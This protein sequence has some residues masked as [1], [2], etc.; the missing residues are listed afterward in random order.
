[1][2]Y[3]FPK[4]FMPSRSTNICSDT[5]NW[6][7]MKPICDMLLNWTLL[8]NFKFNKITLN[9]HWIF[10]TG[11]ACKPRTLTPTDTSSQFRELHVIQRWDSFLRGPLALGILAWLQLLLWMSLDIFNILFLSPLIFMCWFIWS[12]RSVLLLVVGLYKKN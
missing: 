11:V 12:L 4:W 9:F 3:P 7:H 1:M 5:I 8:T 2:N 10:A 6:W